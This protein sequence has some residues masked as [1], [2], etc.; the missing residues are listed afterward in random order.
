[1]TKIILCA[2][3]KG[4]VG[5]STISL[6]LS[7][8]LSKFSRVAI[9]DMDHQGS[10]MQLREQFQDFE[11]SNSKLLLS[12][13]LDYDIIIVDT[14]PYLSNELSQ[15]IQI[16][17]LIIIPTKAGILDVLAISSTIDLIKQE[18]MESK[19]LIV[20]NMIKP[21]TTLTKDIM[22]SLEPFKIEVAKTKISDLVAFTRSAA[23]RSVSYN[24]KAQA[25][26]NCLTQEI[27]TRLL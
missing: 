22:E 18:K 13:D 1:M 7:I 8:S 6:L 16:A 11:I 19:A 3:Q 17:D 14:P 5:K 23:L 25:Q 21:K 20:L 4:G 2:H 12:N 27:L 9:L 15:L 26:L 10:L 24:S